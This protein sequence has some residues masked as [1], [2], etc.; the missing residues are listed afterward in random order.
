MNS[1]FL[2]CG[3]LLFLS[4]VSTTLSAR[5]GMPLLL[6]FLAVGM[7]AGED[8]IGRVDFDNFVQA[9]VISQLALAV[10]LLDGGLRTRT[11]LESFRIALKPSAV[12]A[13]W[14]VFATVLLLGLFTTFYL[15]SDWKFG[16]LMAAIVGSTDAGAVFSLLRNSGVRLNERVQA[17]LEIESGANDPMAV[18]LVT[19]LIGLIMQPERS[20]VLSFLWMLVRQLGFGLLLGWL[21]GK[22]L[23]KLVGR[24][25]LAEGLYA[26]MIVSGGLL[27]F[28]FTNLIGGSGFLAVYLAGIIVGNQHSRATEH[29]LRVMDGLAWLAQATMFV[30][31]GLLVT[32]TS[33]LE[34]G[35]DALV[36][37]V[38]L[39]L[40]AR[41]A[42]VFGGLWKFHYSL[43][44]KA[45][46]SWL[47]LRGA[48]PISLAMMPLVM[49]VP[50]SKLLFDVAFAVVILS[51]L[52]QGT[53]IPVMARW[54]KVAVPP[55]PEPKDTRDIWLAE[56]EAVR[57]TAYCVA[58]DSEAEG[59]HP[60]KVAPISSSFELRCFAL[61]RGGGRIALHGDTALQA[62]DLAQ[63]Y[64]LRLNDG[65]ES[66]SLYELFEMRADSKYPVEG[67]RIEI[68][69]FMLIVK[70]LDKNGTIKWLGLKCPQ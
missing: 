24:L 22:I 26:L 40:V 68:G 46:I 51:L 32:P 42:A 49:G 15:G 1:L 19:A 48:V 29:V 38:F 33:V 62:G 60:D 66:L 20:G 37:A 50:N 55:K 21:G 35:A 12:L 41:P 2:L 63:A 36:I 34:K 18:F 25:N 64:G 30:V 6:V 57:L 5:L 65:E 17:T 14:G 8:G 23:A 28:A 54:L 43:R 53:T 61:I 69:G 58:A 9:N 10:I 52:I 4:V 44:E 7:L 45:Y 16:I 27:V 47:G 70:E 67:D 39:M 59:M 11:R 56:R 3:A 13:T 31:L